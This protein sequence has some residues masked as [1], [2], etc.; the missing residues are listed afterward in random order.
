MTHREFFSPTMMVLGNI[1]QDAGGKTAAVLFLLEF[2]NQCLILLFFS[3]IITAKPFFTQVAN[4]L[5]PT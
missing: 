1:H 5:L 2:I 4:L 3:V